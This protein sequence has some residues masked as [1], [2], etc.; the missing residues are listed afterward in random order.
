[1]RTGNSRVG[2]CVI[3]RVW[4]LAACGLLLLVVSQASCGEGTAALA[5]PAA[6]GSGAS[7]GESDLA[8]GQAVAPPG[9]AVERDDA[10]GR[11][12]VLIDG[13]EAFAFHYGADLDL[14][15]ILPRS[16]SGKAMTVV[17]TDPYP[18]H[19]SVW[20][21]DTVQL[22]GE[23]QASFYN[24]LYSRAD[25]KDPASPFQDRIRVVGMDPPRLEGRQAALDARLLWE[26]DRKTSVL[27]E[28]RQM[29]VVALGGGEYLLD[30][31]FTVTASYG[32]VTFT[33][34]AVH[35]A[36]PYVRMDPAF[37][38]D[39]GGTMTN[40]E[41]GRNQAGTCDKE[42]RWVDYSAPV[43][44]VVEGLAVF[45]HPDNGPPPRWLT[46]DYGT[47]GPRREAAKSGTRFTLAKGQSLKQR[48]GIL[49]HAGDAAAGRVEQRYRLYA[50]GG[51]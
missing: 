40:S 11:L 17:R 26:M 19:R 4:P 45:S 38:V 1:M 50:R 20:F 10:A 34:D 43:G 6:R 22:A 37:S 51:L 15:Y 25:K 30:L 21:A 5:V 31:T 41:G 3:S 16:P 39:K 27:D 7:G 42:A 29:R 8:T 49:V 44:G 28:A 36:W 9:L 2:R 14:P 32:D 47:F 35:Y 18:H 48:V 33:S 23:R 13:K 46:R 24:A 12:R